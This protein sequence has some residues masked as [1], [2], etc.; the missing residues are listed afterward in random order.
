MHARY[1][2]KRISVALG[3]WHKNRGKHQGEIS[4]ACLV[5]MQLGNNMLHG[6]YVLY[7]VCQLNSTHQLA[8]CA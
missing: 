8:F 2:S 7:S 6:F 5:C 4:C 1:N 3:N